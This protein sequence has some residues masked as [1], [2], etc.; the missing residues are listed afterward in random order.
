M[1][2]NGKYVFI[3]QRNNTL[4]NLAQLKKFYDK[5]ENMPTL[6]ANRVLKKL[7]KKWQNKVINKGR[8]KRRLKRKNYKLIN[9]LG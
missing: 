7:I 5:I 4:P 1:I 9:K 3:A 8:V 2:I 6:R